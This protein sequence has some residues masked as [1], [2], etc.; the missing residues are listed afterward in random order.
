MARAGRGPLLLFALVALAG[1]LLFAILTSGFQAVTSDGAR[2]LALERAPRAL[3]AIE[4]IDSAGQPFSLASLAGPARHTTLLTLTYTSCTSICRTSVAGQAYLQQQLRAHHLEAR[5][6]LLT[7]SF[8]PARDNPA[9]LR[10][11]GRGMKADPALWRL[12]TVTSPA[13]LAALLK[14][15][16]VVVLADGLGGW[17][18]NGALFMVDG[19]NRLM[20]AYDIDQPDQALADLLED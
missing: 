20:R 13:G 8:D 18:H 17:V 12:A 19:Q 15:F 3:P 11:Y 9:A 4:L 2:R 5:V 6:R 7:I 14:L 10:A 1:A 16:E